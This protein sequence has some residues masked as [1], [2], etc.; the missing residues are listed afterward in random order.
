MLEQPKTGWHF[1]LAD[2]QDPETEYFTST[3]F[4]YVILLYSLNVTMR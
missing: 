4:H 1:R 2:D 3:K